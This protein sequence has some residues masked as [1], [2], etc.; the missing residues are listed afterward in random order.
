VQDN[1]RRKIYVTLTRLWPPQAAW[2]CSVLSATV[3]CA[4]KQL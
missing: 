3:L 1:K 2:D 4:L